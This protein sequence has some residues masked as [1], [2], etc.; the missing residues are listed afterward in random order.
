MK[1]ALVMAA[2]CLAT[3]L[4][5]TLLR[6]D[7]AVEVFLGMCG[8]LVAVLGTWFAVEHGV[9]VNPAGLTSLMVTGFVAKMVFFAVYVVAVV[10]LARL[11]HAVFALSFAAY[12]I[13]LYAAE[14]VLLRRLFQRLT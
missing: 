11:D 13:A 10:S 7:A 1:W 14:A 3:W 2:V 6:P 4:A 5:W 9:R 8:P 12:F